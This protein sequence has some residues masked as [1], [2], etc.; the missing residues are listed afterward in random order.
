M[1][2]LHGTAVLC[3]TSPPFRG[4]RDRKTR[5]MEEHFEPHQVEALAGIRGRKALADSGQAGT[6]QEQFDRE[7][8][9]FE[10]FGDGVHRLR[11]F[12]HL[13]RK[14]V[15]FHKSLTSHIGEEGVTPRVGQ[16]LGRCPTPL[17]RD[18][19]RQ[20]CKGPGRLLLQPSMNV[21]LRV[22]GEKAFNALPLWDLHPWSTPWN[23]GRDSMEGWSLGDQ[24]V[25]EEFHVRIMGLYHGPKGPTVLVTYGLEVRD[26]RTLT[27]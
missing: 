11:G 13:D 8:A 20:R 19:L 18:D 21:L 1:F 27:S 17:A 24:F 10:N 7:V 25:A 16:I 6:R 15:P 26:D 14:F 2:R 12:E 5:A 23:A 4:A 9:A 3:R 22:L